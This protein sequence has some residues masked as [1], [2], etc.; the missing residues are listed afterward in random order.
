MKFICEAPNS[1]IDEILTY[2]E[3]LDH[4]EKDNMDIDSD[5]NNCKSSVVSQHTKAP[6][7]HRT[8]TTKDQLT[9]F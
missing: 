8:R 5:T 4:I 3:I 7:G 1:T 2:N 9:T 6:F